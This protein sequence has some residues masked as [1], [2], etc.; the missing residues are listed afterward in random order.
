MQHGDPQRYR[1]PVPYP[2][3]L[4]GVRPNEMDWYRVDRP[5]WY[6]GEGWA[7][8]PESAGVAAADG[9]VL[10]R[11]SIDGWIHR[12]TGGGTLMIGYDNRS[13]TFTQKNPTTSVSIPNN[14]QNEDLTTSLAYIAIE[15]NLRINLGSRFGSHQPANSIDRSRAATN[16]SLTA[17]RNRWSSNLRKAAAVVPPGEVTASRS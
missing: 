1:W 6:V 8:T 15:P 2:V 14:P 7:L 4:S 17:A 16:A 9:R 12:G 3:L 10:A 13:V 5:E 11:G